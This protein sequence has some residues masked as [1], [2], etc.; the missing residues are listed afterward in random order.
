MGGLGMALGVYTNSMSYKFSDNL[1]VQTDIS[2][3]NSPYNNFSKNFQNNINGIY[4][5]R[6]ALNYKPF[7]DMSI[8]IQ[9]RNLPASLYLNNWSRYSPFGYNDMWGY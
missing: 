2:I 5:S 6:A 1:N 8:S 3:V 7:K 9:Y 4:L